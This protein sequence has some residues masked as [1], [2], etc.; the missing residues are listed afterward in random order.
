MRSECERVGNL[1]S[2]YV[3]DGLSPAERAY[4]A[5]HVEVCEKCSR[6]LERARRLVGRLGGLSEE[7]PPYDLWPAIAHKISTPPRGRTIKDRVVALV[8][9]RVIAVSAAA[10]TAVLLIFLAHPVHQPGPAD[11]GRD[12]AESSAEYRAY[13]QAYASFRGQQSLTDRD[14]V[15]AAAQLQHNESAP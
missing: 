4:V 10:A 14:V 8:G 6:E 11:R 7:K 2:D 9:W 15:A 3:D 1:I 13:T 12:V 5:A